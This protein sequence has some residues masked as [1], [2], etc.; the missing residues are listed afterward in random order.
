MLIHKRTGMAGRRGRGRFFFPPSQLDEA[1]ISPAG[2][3]SPAY[4]LS[5]DT[6]LLQAYAIIDAYSPS[7]GP[8][9]LHGEPWVEGSDPP[10]FSPAPDPTAITSFTLDTRVATQRRRLRR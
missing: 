8:V 1:D 6:N 10:V 5:I 7:A 9:L 4:V 2:F 3:L